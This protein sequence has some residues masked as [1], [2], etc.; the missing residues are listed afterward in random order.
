MNFL[1]DF[2]PYIEIIVTLDYSISQKL[3]TL[4]MHL[5]SNHNLR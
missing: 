3:I 4:S 1:S 5:Y 2:I